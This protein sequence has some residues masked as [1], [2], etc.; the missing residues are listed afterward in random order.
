MLNLMNG[1]F[2][3]ILVIHAGA[4]A[5]QYKSNK[6]RA[7]TQIW[8]ILALY[9]IHYVHNNNI[10]NEVNMC[11]LPWLQRNYQ[12]ITKFVEIE[13]RFDKIYKLTLLCPCAVANLTKTIWFSF[14]WFLLYKQIYKN[15]IFRN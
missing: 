6:N 10:K 15:G 12:K 8:I 5:Y 2:E 13:G 9:L 11:N 14:R 3:N 7:V 4:R 1:V